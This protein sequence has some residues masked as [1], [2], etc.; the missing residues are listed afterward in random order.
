MKAT[1]AAPALG[2]SSDGAASAASGR[3]RWFWPGMAVGWVLI[4]VG[5]GGMVVQRS[6]THPLG[7]GRYVVGFLLVHDLV[8]APIALG[9]AWLVGRLVPPIARGPVRAALAL[10]AL[11]AA[12]A[13]PLLRRYGTHATNDSALPLDYGRTVPVVIAAVWAG[14]AVAVL[15]K[16][17][18]GRRRRAGR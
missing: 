13:W 17:S 2:A 1:T 15:V 7:L 11:I 6:R 4:G 18:A 10:T 16:L 3:S 5:V 14:A 12:F 9:G 8:V